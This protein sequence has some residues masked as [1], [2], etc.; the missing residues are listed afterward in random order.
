[1]TLGSATNV[2]AG[3]LRL[4]HYERSVELAH[5]ELE[6][7]E[8]LAASLERN[9]LFGRWYKADL[10]ALH[11][12]LAPLDD[13]EKLTCMP[14]G[15]AHGIRKLLVIEMARRRTSY[16]AW[17][18]AD[19]ADMVCRDHRGFAARY[20]VIK[21]ARLHVMAFGYAVGGIQEPRDISD[22]FVPYLFARASF[23][24]EPVNDAVR[25]CSVVLEKWGTGKWFLVDRLQPGVSEVLIAAR[26]ARLS[27]VTSE[28]V[29]RA[30]RGTH[31][32][33][34]AVIVH[35]SRVLTEM[36]IVAQPI[37]GAFE[38][39]RGVGI[40]VS[41]APEAWIRWA[42]RW[43]ETSTLEP[44]TREQYVRVLVRSGTLASAHLPRRRRSYRVDPLN[45]R[46]MCSRHRSPQY[47]R[48]GGTSAPS[49]GAASG[50]AVDAARES[51]LSQGAPGVL[52]RLPGMGVVPVAVQSTPVVCH[53]S[54]PG[55]ANSPRSTRCG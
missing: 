31:R 37:L 33:L 13:L 55:C 21:G 49:S 19:W 42:R 30:W 12:L 29:Q 6:V 45:R 52:S 47:R 5:A 53:A 10:C 15:R 39:P 9:A 11:R 22:A 25:S 20:H 24:R 8:R 27:D 43:Y 2:R 51:W 48:L 1:M 18:Q 34:R 36:Q 26:T 23:G 54:Q 38:T 7:I 14:E 35:I 41:G 32:E 3:P 40:D 17:S 4:E 28:A 46:S 44:R 50:Q 16:W